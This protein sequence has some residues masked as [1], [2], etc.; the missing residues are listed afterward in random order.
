MPFR[1][2]HSSISVEH[3]PLKQKRRGKNMSTLEDNSV[4]PSLL[5][6]LADLFPLKQ[7][8]QHTFQVM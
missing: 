7:E 8:G 6:K 4:F 1:S 5:K 3:L 2:G